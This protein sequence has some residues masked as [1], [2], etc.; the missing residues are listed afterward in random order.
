MTK[1]ELLTHHKMVEYKPEPDECVLWHHEV[2]EGDQRWAVIMNT[3]HELIDLVEIPM[4]ATEEEILQIL[5]QKYNHV[6]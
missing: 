2:E 1:Q 3:V 4:D 6:A 5:T